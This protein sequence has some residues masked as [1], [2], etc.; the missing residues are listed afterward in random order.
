MTKQ[1][2]N[3]QKEKEIFFYFSP[4]P[5]CPEEILDRSEFRP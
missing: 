4:I 1:K 5:S 2:H 3:K